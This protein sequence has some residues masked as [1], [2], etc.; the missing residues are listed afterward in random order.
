MFEETQNENENRL[1]NMAGLENEPKKPTLSEQAFE[2]A[3]SVYKCGESF[4]A[5]SQLNSF[6]APCYRVGGKML[7]T[8]NF[9]IIIGG[10]NPNISK[11][12]LKDVWR[13]NFLTRRWKMLDDVKNIPESTVAYS[14]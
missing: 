6:L 14:S 1:G 2:W 7:S 8:E 13:Y 11:T 10:S 12:V 9:L 5:V 3:K 4:K